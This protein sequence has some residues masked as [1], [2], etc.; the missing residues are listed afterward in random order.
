ML[1]PILFE[2]CINK[3]LYNEKF[4]RYYNSEYIYNK[5]ELIIGFIIEE[6]VK[7]KSS[8]TFI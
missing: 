3:D 5:K 2:F 8:S 7:F 4:L 1:L 6:I